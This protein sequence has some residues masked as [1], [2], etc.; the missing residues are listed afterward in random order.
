MTVNY[1]W[2]DWLKCNLHVTL[3]YLKNYGIEPAKGGG[4]ISFVGALLIIAKTKKIKMIQQFAAFL[5]PPLFD[6][7]VTLTRN[8]YLLTINV[9]I[10][11][12]NKKST[13]TCKISRENTEPLQKSHVLIDQNWFHVK[14]KWQN[15]FLFSTRYA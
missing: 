6:T 11:C 13:L 12:K 7:Y 1:I 8:W 2:F 3:H 5:N 15:F 10:M 4:K 9:S 14:C